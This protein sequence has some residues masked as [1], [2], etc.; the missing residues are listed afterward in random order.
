M[1][2][3]LLLRRGGGHGIGLKSLKMGGQLAFDLMDLNL[4]AKAAIATKSSTRAAREPD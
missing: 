1:T 3:I 4:T 2:I